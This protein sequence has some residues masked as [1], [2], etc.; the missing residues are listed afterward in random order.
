MTANEEYVAEI[1]CMDEFELLG[2]ILLS[3]EYL[4]DDYYK[5]FGQALTAR[6]KELIGKRVVHDVVSVHD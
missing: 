2:E 1:A 4:T 6:G 3:P 5:E